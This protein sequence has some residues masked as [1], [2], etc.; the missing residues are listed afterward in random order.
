MNLQTTIA[1]MALFL[2]ALG[3]ACAGPQ[4]EAEEQIGYPPGTIF[5]EWTVETI[6]GSAVVDGSSPYLGFGEDGR[7]YGNTSVNQLIGAWTLEE[8]VLALKQL[9][10]TRMAG[11][12]ALMK[13]EA[14]LLKALPLATHVTFSLD[15]RLHLRSADSAPLVVGSRRNN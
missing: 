3:S 15:G 12:P 2:C 13:Q 9:G 14:K 8:G 4:S 7:A 5:G 11:S 6:M 1:G 10:S